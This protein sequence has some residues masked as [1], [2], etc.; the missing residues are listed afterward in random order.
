M[1]IDSDMAGYRQYFSACPSC[2]GWVCTCSCK[3]NEDVE[4][5]L[6]IFDALA[7]QAVWKGLQTGTVYITL[8]MSIEGV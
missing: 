1:R 5:E 3:R 6:L 2:G 4:F 8:G 7:G